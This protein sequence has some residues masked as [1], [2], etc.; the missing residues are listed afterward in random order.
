M[1][2]KGAVEVSLI[3][4]ENASCISKLKFMLSLRLVLR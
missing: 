3:G 4:P 1:C 2:K